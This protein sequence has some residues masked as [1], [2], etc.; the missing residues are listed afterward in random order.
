MPIMI[1]GTEKKVTLR[2]VAEH[3]LICGT[4]SA[5]PTR[6]LGAKAAILAEHCA[7]RR[8]PIRSRRSPRSGAS[9]TGNVEEGGASSREAGVTHFTVGIGGQNGRYDLGRLRDVLAWREGLRGE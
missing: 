3:A 1:G 8:P 6:Y 7:K 5:T 9:R 2:I 4:A